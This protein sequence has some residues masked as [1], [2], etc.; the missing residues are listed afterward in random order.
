MRTLIHFDPGT[1]S[2]ITS[3]LFVEDKVDIIDPFA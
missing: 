2:G 3:F 1:D